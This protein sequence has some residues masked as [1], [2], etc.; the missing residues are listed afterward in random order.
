MAMNGKKRL[1]YII[2]G[3]FALLSLAGS[4]SA[5]LSFLLPKIPRDSAYIKSY[6]EYVVGRV[7]ITQKYVS[8]G[9][10]ATAERPAFRYKP[11]NKLNLGLGLTYRIFTLN[12]GFGFPGLNGDGSQRG[13]TRALDLQ[14]SI[15]GRR[16]MF[17]L[18][19]QSYKGYYI[20]PENFISAYKGYY[21]RPDM[22]V[23]MVG[24]SAYYVFNPGRF[25]Y[26]AAMIQ[27]E[28]QQK[29]AGTFLASF[30]IF[31]GAV[32]GEQGSI[33]P[34]EI[35]DPAQGIVE[36][37]RFINFGPGAGYAYH[38][39]WKK[40][41]YAMAS[42]VVNLTADF[43]REFYAEEKK[44]RLS[45]SPNASFLFS[46]GYNSRK[47]SLG[48]SVVNNTINVKGSA[49]NNPYVIR[50]GNYKLTFA[51]RFRPTKNTRKILKSV[52]KVLIDKK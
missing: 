15:Y 5:Q 52:D 25:S 7:F 21:T 3:C 32:N 13:K 41:L 6:Q 42:L 50:S 10:G 40:H 20:A 17:D 24:G 33:L 46:T 51:H 43:S 30:D 22:R 11:N 48:F 47:W 34:P 19:G 9:I 36:R 18:F 14:T 44:D 45:I 49:N 39:V 23:Q 37:L 28:W 4:A 2:G 31:Y 8:V 29:S 12:V 1:L 35:A 26:R 27:D 16:W 38:F